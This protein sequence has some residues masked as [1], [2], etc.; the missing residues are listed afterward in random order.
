[1]NVTLISFGD[2]KWEKALVRLESQAKQIP[3]IKNIFILNTE[4]LNKETNFYKDNQ[5]FIDSHPKGHGAWIWKSYIIEKAFEKFP[6]SDFYIYLDSGSELNVNENTVERFLSYFKIAEDQSIFAMVNRDGE[7]NL[8]HCSVIDRIYPPA[9]ETNQFEAGTLIF[10]NDLKSLG[11]VKEWKR[12]C[13]EDD[14]FNVRPKDIYNCCD[15]WG[16]IHLHDQS[17]LSCLLKKN[18][19]NGIFDESSWYL[20]STS[21]SNDIKSNR[22]KYPI[23]TARNP[24]EYSIIN[25]DCIQYLGFKICIHDGECPDMTVVR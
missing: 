23:F 12:L 22:D 17:V 1:M 4:L 21:V 15:L 9:K 25:K 16:G 24:F 14:Y 8:S 2:E 7:K 20:P 18:K 19:I 3:F 10:K 13:I 6:E 5:D 11:I